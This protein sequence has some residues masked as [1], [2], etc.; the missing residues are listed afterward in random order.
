MSLNALGV[1]SRT[2]RIFGQIAAGDTPNA[3]DAADALIAFNAM[4]RAWFGAL[5]GP[6]LT[7]IGLA[8]ASAQAENG[9]E[10]TLPQSAFTLYAPRNPRPGN[11]FGVLDVYGD[12][13]ACPCTINPSGRS[14]STVANGGNLVFGANG[15]S[16]RFWYRGDTGAWVQEG[17]TPT[18]TSAIEFPDPIIAYFPYMLAVVMAAEFSGDLSP[19]VEAANLEGR[20][21]L[22]RT[23]GRRG[24][25]Q[26]E[27]PIGLGA[28]AG[29][30]QVG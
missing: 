1:I 17:D 27:G 14:F 20:A 5:I 21:V 26:P 3:N 30:Q 10:Y 2:F 19:E 23:Y 13:A 24:R 29:L 6:R 7:S 22:A 18:L 15:Q 16:G 25:A 28:P 9:G 12:F 11:R 8:G 4:K